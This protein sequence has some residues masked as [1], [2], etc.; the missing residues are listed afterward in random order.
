[1]D[2]QSKEKYID[3]LERFFKKGVEIFINN[4][5][6][7]SREEWFE[8]LQVKENDTSYYVADFIDDGSGKLREIRF[9]KITKK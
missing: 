7:S 9:N 3:G 4:K 5:Y 1:M 2:K 6:S 8:I